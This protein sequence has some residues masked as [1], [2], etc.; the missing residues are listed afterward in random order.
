MRKFVTYYRPAVD[1]PDH[2]YLDM[3]VQKLLSE[4]S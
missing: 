3:E 2:L 4:T 1:Q